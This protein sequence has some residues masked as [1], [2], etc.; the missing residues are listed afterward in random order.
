M[1]KPSYEL[2]DQVESGKIIGILDPRLYVTLYP[3]ASYDLWNKNYPN[4]HTKPLYYIKLDSP[5]KAC[6]VE[7]LQEFHPDKDFFTL[8]QMH[9]AMP[10]IPI[11]ILPQDAVK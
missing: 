2:L 1:I 6:T 5:S 7:E 9:E 3:N 8:Q 11:L 4:W 10:L